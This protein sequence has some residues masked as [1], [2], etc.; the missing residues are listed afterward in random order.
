MSSDAV[1]YDAKSL[2]LSEYHGVLSTHSVDVAGFPFGSVAP[3]CLDSEGRAVI[4]ISSIAQHTKN[5][6][7]NN[8]V[9]LIVTEGAVDDVHTAARLT[10]LAEAVKVSDADEDTKERYYQFFPPARDYHSQHNFHF[11]RL[12]TVKARYIGGFGKIHWVPASDLLHQ[13]AFAGEEEQRMVTHMNKDHGAAIQKYCVDYNI[14]TKNRVDPVMVGVD[15]QGCHIRVGE[16]VTRINF[17]EPALDAMAVRER[18]VA[19]ARA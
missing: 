4:L 15:C 8:K 3:Y 9:S 16:R 7:A 18:L 12:N 6:Q 17:S 5:I 19:M 10:L 1:T 13:V 11:Y 2:L 14:A